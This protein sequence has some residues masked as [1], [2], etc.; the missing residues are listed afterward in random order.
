MHVAMMD[1]VQSPQAAEPCGREHERR[2]CAR[3]LTSTVTIS[4]AHHGAAIQ[5][6][7]PKCD[8][9]AH[10]A[11]A[12]VTAGM[13]EAIRPFRIPSPK[14]V[15]QRRLRSASPGNLRGE[16]F[17][18]AEQDDRAPERQKQAVLADEALHDIN[19]APLRR[20]PA[21]GIDRIARAV[22]FPQHPPVDDVSG[23]AVRRIGEDDRRLHGDIGRGAEQVEHRIFHPFQKHRN[24]MLLAPAMNPCSRSGDRSR[25]RSHAPAAAP[26]R[27]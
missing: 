19:S 2:T 12:T 11:E 9:W 8:C 13:A 23:M 1:A 16:K 25:A 21:A 7:K 24:A 20:P 4:A 18:R 5:F 22:L 10:N 14:L 15:G 17:D 26:P 27:R 3:L 6:S